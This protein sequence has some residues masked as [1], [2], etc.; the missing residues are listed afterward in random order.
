MGPFCSQIDQFHPF[1]VPLAEQKDQMYLKKNI[2]GP[3]IL[4]RALGAPS[5]EP[6][7]SYLIFSDEVQALLNL[8]DKSSCTCTEDGP[9]TR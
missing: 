9:K 4:G 1:M 8:L 5:P 2:F 3:S 6:F 7:L